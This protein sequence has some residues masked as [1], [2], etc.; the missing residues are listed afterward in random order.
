[1]IRAT[2]LKQLTVAGIEGTADFVHKKQMVHSS[3]GKQTAIYQTGHTAVLL[4]FPKH[5]L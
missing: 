2:I 3:Y 1:L 4:E 5:T